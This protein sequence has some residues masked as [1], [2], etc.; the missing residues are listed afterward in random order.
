M[1]VDHL[2]LADP[3]DPDATM[4][5][6]STIEQAKRSNLYSL[7]A[8]VGL[9]G[10]LRKYGLAP[11]QFAENLRDNYVNVMKLSSIRLCD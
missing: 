3:D 6:E 5:E 4:D 2:N 9:N 8:R 7:C 10:L 11:E 1:D